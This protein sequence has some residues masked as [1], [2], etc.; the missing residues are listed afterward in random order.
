MNIVYTGNR[1]DAEDIVKCVGNI[2]SSI[3]GTVP[4]VR[5]LGIDDRVVSSPEASIEGIYMAEIE[6]QV[7]I[8]DERVLVDEIELSRNNARLDAEVTVKDGES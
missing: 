6:D 4:Y 8:W 2:I 7:A 5:N 3:K 1:T